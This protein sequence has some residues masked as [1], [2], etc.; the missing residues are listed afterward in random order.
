MIPEI[1]KILYATDLSESALHAFGYAVSLSSRYQA[2]LTVLHVLEE[3]SASVQMQVKSIIGHEKWLQA[4]DEI[5]RT[6]TA[7][8]QARLE[9]LCGDMRTRADQCTFAKPE[10]VIAHGHPV[11]TILEQSTR[12]NS[13]LIVMGTHGF[14]TFRDTW[15]GSTA[16]RVLH[17]SRIPVLT[18]RLPD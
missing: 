7:K 8:I 3:L 13:D 1:K 10:I 14:G 18:I 16:R 15:M 2:G 4:M 5:S 9:K 17:R 12:R 6:A 11:Q